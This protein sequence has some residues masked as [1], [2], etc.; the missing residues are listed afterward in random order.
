MNFQISGQTRGAFKGWPRGCSCT[1]TPSRRELSPGR[2]WDQENRG[3]AAGACLG[4]L[5]QVSAMLKAAAI[6]WAL[7][8]LL[9][10]APAVT[11][12]TGERQELHESAGKEKDTET[13]M[14]ANM[15]DC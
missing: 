7:V 5:P 15:L 9:D 3:R 6:P 10:P 2:R 1:S 11:P 13:Q 4:N 12:R 8:W 14:S